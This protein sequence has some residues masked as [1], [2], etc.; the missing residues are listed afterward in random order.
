MCIRLSNLEGFRGRKIEDEIHEIESFFFI[1]KQKQGRKSNGWSPGAKQ[2]SQA[3]VTVTHVKQWKHTRTPTQ[4]TQHQHQLRGTTP[5]LSAKPRHKKCQQATV[6]RSTAQIPNRPVDS[7][8]IFTHWCTLVGKMFFQ[9]VTGHA[10]SVALLWS[11]TLAAIINQHVFV[12]TLFF[13]VHV[14]Y[15]LKLAALALHTLL[16]PPCGLLNNFVR[17]LQTTAESSRLLQASQFPICGW[18][19]LSLLFSVFLCHLMH[20]MLLATQPLARNMQAT[21]AG[22]LEFVHRYK[23]LLLPLPGYETGPQVLFG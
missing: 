13:L 10:L 19:W 3:S 5:S 2:H 15:I 22:A 12:Q 14:F 21:L 18:V 20:K 16:P 23:I 11:F 8:P 6:L 9:L 7:S 1:G 4:Y 17:N